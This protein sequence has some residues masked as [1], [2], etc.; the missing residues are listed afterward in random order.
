[1]V[2]AVTSQILLNYSG[3]S[4]FPELK[5][6]GNEGPLVPHFVVPLDF[7]GRVLPAFHPEHELLL[8]DP[9]PELSLDH[10]GRFVLTQDLGTGFK[11][12]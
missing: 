10:R 3:H 6:F 8:V 1:M 12:D 11:L 7:D 2:H 5:G 9:V 4:I